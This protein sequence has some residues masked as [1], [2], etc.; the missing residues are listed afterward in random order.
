MQTE[1]LYFEQPYLVKFEANI[2][3]TE[4]RSEFSAVILDKTAFYPTSGGQMCDTGF[5]NEIKVEK[6]IEE[7]NSVVHLL[8]SAI[9]TTQVTCRIDWQRRF[10]FMQQHTAFHI[11]AQCFLRM[12]KADTL[13][14]HLGEII[15]TIDVNIENINSEQI[16]QV[17]QLANQIC[18]ENRIVKQ[19]FLNQ[20]EIGKYS[21]RAQPSKGDKTRIVEIDN[22]DIDPCGGTHVSS[23]GQVGVIKIITWEKIRGNLRFE[24]LAGKRSIDDYQKKWKINRDISNLLTESQ[25]N[26]LTSVEKLQTEVKSLLKQNSKLNKLNLDYEAKEIIAEANKQD[27]KIIKLN[28]V[29]R[30]LSDIR[31]LANQ[32][33]K[34]SDLWLL[35]GLQAEKAHLIFAHPESH[36][37]NLNELFKQVIHLI[38]GRG[39]GR[40]N[41]VEAGGKNKKGIDEALE[42]ARLIIKN[43]ILK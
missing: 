10:D 4:Q 37:Y 5:I 13:S 33:I 22:F 32:I 36:N 2:I 7:N 28:F 12:L 25:D 1:R 21:L 8:E 17:E 18:F 20:N 34:Q 43:S 3:H 24:F 9:D 30:Q 31:Y 11:L 42:S 27:Q 38:D 6:V 16:M 29:D 41:F 14:S 39:G 35:F 15:S 40:P 26:L 23:T 19:F